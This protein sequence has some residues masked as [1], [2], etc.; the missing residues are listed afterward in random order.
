MLSLACSNSGSGTATPDAHT[1]VAVDPI[2]FPDAPTE[3]VTGNPSVCHGP[4]SSG[5][6][7]A[8]L[9][10]VSRDADIESLLTEPEAADFPIFPVQV[11]PATTCTRAVAFGR[12]VE[13]RKYVATVWTY[14]DMDGDPDTVDVCTIDGTSV[15]VTRINGQC[16]TT[17]AT[18]VAQLTCYGW[19]R[20]TTE[21]AG[22]TNS[23]PSCDELG[24]P[25]IA[26]E[27]RLMTLHYCVVDR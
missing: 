6:Y 10:D 20:P 21:T 17:P 7:V 25:G 8:E 11:S 9:I 19:Q 13:N 24:C 3:G 22:S 12:V 1:L 27:Y 16:T 5:A 4:N 14:A 26:L 2:D 23:N 18:P 15:T